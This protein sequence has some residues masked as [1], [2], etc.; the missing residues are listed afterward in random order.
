MPSNRTGSGTALLLLAPSLTTLAV[1]AIALSALL[2]QS[3]LEFVP[4]SLRTGG[5]TTGNF[6]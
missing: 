1:F 5:F 4:G 3:V 2:Q 6:R